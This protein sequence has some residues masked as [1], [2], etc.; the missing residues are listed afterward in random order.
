MVWKTLI[1]SAAVLISPAAVAQDLNSA[2]ERTAACLNIED[3]AARLACFEE[4]ATAL[5]DV[6]EEVPAADG[7]V[8]TEKSSPVASIQKE[9]APEADLPRWADA[10]TPKPEPAVQAS[11]AASANADADEEKNTPI[12]ARIIPKS[13][14]DAAADSVNLTVT[15]I[16]RNSFGRHFFITEDGQ[17]WEQTAPEDVAP[18][19]R[20][21]AKVTIRRSVLGSPALSFDDGTPGLYKVR[22]VK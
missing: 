16:L 1:V 10:P 4:A 20:L 22:R 7:S 12:W 5:S 8:E 2:A 9:P 6:L 18:P 14:K 13:D 11:A 17:E 3:A 19:K 15:R 21:P